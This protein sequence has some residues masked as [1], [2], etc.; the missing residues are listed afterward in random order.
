[1]FAPIT[2]RGK[3]ELVVTA[4]GAQYLIYEQLYKTYGTTNFTL[5]VSMSY[6]DPSTHLT[7]SGVGYVLVRVLEV[8]LPPTINSMSFNV[9]ENVTIGS[10]VGVVVNAPIIL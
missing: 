1:M 5:G 4:A 3:A 9:Y 8:P 2:V 10:S 7:V 6:L